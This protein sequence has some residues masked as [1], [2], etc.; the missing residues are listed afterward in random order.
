MKW[1]DEWEVDRMARRVFSMSTQDASNISLEHWT[2]TLSVETHC[3]AFDELLLIDYGSCR[4]M[5][6]QTE[7]LLISGDAV[8]VGC[9]ESHGF[10]MRGKVSVY[11]LQFSESEL[12]PDVRHF[13]SQAVLAIGGYA[14]ETVDADPLEEPARREDC[15]KE[16][17]DWGS[18]YV[19]NCNRQ[20]VIHLT[21]SSYAFV[22]SML[23]QGLAAQ[24]EG[25]VLS[26]AEKKRCLDLVLLEICQAVTSRQQ[27]TSVYSRAHQEI[28]AEVLQYIDKHLDDEI[29]FHALAAEQAFSLGYFRKLFKDVT[30]FSPVAYTNRLRIIKACAYLQQGLLVSEAAERVGIYDLN[31][32]SRLFKKIMGVSPSRLQ[33]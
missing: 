23:R 28:I 5:Y 32:F 4:H 29:D 19:L 12:A 20:G 8:L 9:G 6:R 17:I 33:A 27:R 3:H 25:T 22:V 1:I 31:Y 30:G 26:L 24:G 2:N 10:S 7:T 13:L 11:N 16:S 21:P 15:Y 14:R 18:G